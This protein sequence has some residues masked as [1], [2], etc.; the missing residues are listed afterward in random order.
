[1]P[2][3]L[4][5]MVFAASILLLLNLYLLQKRL[6]SRASRA[7]DGFFDFDDSDGCYDAGPPKVPGVTD[8][9][10]IL[11]KKPPS[12]KLLGV[13]PRVLLISWRVFVVITVL[14]GF[15]ASSISVCVW[16]GWLPER[17]G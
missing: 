6:S 3:P 16:L 15:L 13:F 11:K 1:M 2:P 17:L 4:S 10:R 14:T 5:L 12:R 8:K 7:V 9:D